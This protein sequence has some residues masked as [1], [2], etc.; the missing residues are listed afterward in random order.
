MRSIS[1][2][3]LIAGVVALL[4]AYGWG[5]GGALA[6]PIRSASECKYSHV[7]GTAWRQIDSQYPSHEFLYRAI[8]LCG[9]G[10]YPVSGGVRFEGIWNDLSLGNKWRPV[11]SE[12]YDPYNLPMTGWVCLV[13]RTEAAGTSERPDALWCSVLCCP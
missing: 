4:P 1:A 7:G 9:R 2:L 5:A 11:Q 10:S 12:P 13:M 3:A 6:E 8:P